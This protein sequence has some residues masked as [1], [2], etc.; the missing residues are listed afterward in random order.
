M[1]HSYPS[2]HD[3]TSL[4]RI[5]LPNNDVTRLTKIDLPNNDVTRSTRIDLPNNDVTRSTRIDLPNNDVTR[6]TKIDLPNSDVT[7]S[8]GI[9]PPYNN[10]TWCRK[11]EV[12]Q[13]SRTLTCTRRFA[14]TCVFAV[15]P[16]SFCLLLCSKF[17]QKVYSKFQH[18]QKCLG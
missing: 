7:S 1:T 3:V 12:V 11:S 4:A 18:K 15:S 6:L 5:E 10:F 9:H 14:F 8:T 2:L 17:R 13:T 16:F